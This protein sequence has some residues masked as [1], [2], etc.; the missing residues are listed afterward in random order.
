M[1]GEKNTALKLQKYQTDGRTLYYILKEILQL[2]GAYIWFS[3]SQLCSA[4][5]GSYQMLWHMRAE[6]KK[7]SPDHQHD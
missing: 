7:K 2:V 1:K 6:H 5:M 4:A 3:Q